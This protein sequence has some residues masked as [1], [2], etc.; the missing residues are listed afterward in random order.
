MGMA[1]QPAQRLLLLIHGTFWPAQ[2]LLRHW[3]REQS[4]CPIQPDGEDASTMWTT[5]RQTWRCLDYA[6][7]SR[8]CVLWM[9][10][11]YIFLY[12]RVFFC[13]DFLPILNGMF[14]NF[15]IEIWTVQQLCMIL[16]EEENKPGLIFSLFHLDHWK[17][18]LSPNSSAAFREISYD[19]ER[20]VSRL[21]Y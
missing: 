13:F 15:T 6:G 9:F 4:A 14:W 8:S 1:G 12:V 18:F 19:G 10:L 17:T 5:C 20:S 2:L 16:P 7:V 11:T 21:K 3:E